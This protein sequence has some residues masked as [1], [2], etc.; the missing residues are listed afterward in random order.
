MRIDVATVDR[1]FKIVNVRLP[2]TQLK[3]TFELGYAGWRYLEGMS[4]DGNRH[5]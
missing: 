1:D 2:A 5:S 3:V 4:A